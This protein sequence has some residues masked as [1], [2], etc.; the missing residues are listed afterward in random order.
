[1]QVV[2][3]PDLSPASTE[4]QCMSLAVLASLEHTTDT[5]EAWFE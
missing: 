2:I 3:V 4:A 5:Y 1:M